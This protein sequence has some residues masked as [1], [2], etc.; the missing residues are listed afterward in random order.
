MRDPQAIYRARV[1]SP[2]SGIDGETPAFLG[3]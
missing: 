3:E 2:S 1:S